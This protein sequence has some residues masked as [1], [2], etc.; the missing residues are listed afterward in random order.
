VNISPSTTLVEAETELAKSKHT[1]RDETKT[2]RL[3]FT[4]TSRF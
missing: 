3:S 1:A 2:N 4:I